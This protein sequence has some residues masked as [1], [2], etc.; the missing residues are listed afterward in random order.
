MMASLATLGLILMATTTN[1]QTFAA[2]QVFYSIGFSGMIFTVD[3]MT[4]D[5]S[6]LRHRGLAFAFTSSPYIIT[7]LAGPKAAEGFYENISWRWAFGTFTIILPVVA[8][9]LFV[10]L[11]RNERKARKNGLLVRERSGRS[12]MQS[13]W[14]Y[15]IEFDG[16]SFQCRWDCAMSLISC[17]CRCFPPCRRSCHLLAAFLTRGLHIRKL[18]ASIN[19]IHAGDWLL[20][21]CGIRL[22]REICSTQTVHTI[23]PAI[24]SHHPRHLH[25]G[26]HIP[27]RVLLLGLILL[28]LLT[29]GQ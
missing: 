29:G 16:Q 12:W 13:I 15:F 19:G 10:L 1:V 9:P 6:K 7:A 5:S 20:D 4:A 2:A 18:E 3:V 27:D 22:V 17:R 8:M 25:S 26:C 23:P 28:I 11:L 24:V 14:H 21:T